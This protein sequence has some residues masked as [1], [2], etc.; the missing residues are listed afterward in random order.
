MDPDVIYGPYTRYPKQMDK[1]ICFLTATHYV[2]SCFVVPD[3]RNLRPL[4]SV[5]DTGSG[6]NLIRD[7][8]LFDSWERCL[9]K[10]E[11]VPRLGDAN[12]RPLRLRGMVPIRARFRNSFY[13]LPFIVAD[14][15]GVDVFSGTR[16]MI[17]HVDF[18]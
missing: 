5:F 16:F 4:P 7:S 17:E 11:T 9:V 13:P 8:A 10:N 1:L 6:P 14:S 3:P 2:V 15:L 12:G 18:I